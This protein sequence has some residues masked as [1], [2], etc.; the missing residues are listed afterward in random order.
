M[1]ANAGTSAGSSY[2]TLDFFIGLLITLAA[3]LANALGLNLTKLDH[4]REENKLVKSR[5]WTR[6]LWLLG[7]G[8]YILSQV[9]G[10]TLALSFL[11]AE[12]VAPLGSS[13]FLP[14]AQNDA[15]IVHTGAKIVYSVVLRFSMLID[16]LQ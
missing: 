2:S 3:S 9:V 5:D 8:L 1:D 10:S 16:T 7:L 14:T 4:I 15:T 13:S 6:P 12:W 11:R